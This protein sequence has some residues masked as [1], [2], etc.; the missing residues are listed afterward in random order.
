MKVVYSFISDTKD[1][2]S[3]NNAKESEIETAGKRHHGMH[4]L[5]PYM[6]I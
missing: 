3:V 5:N 1:K 6:Y 4:I 2:H